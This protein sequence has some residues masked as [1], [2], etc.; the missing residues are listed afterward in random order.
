MLQIWRQPVAWCYSTGPS[1][2]NNPLQPFNA[3]PQ[4]RRES[5][6]RLGAIISF[7][8]AM[9]MV[10]DMLDR[11]I[12]DQ[13]E[14]VFIPLRP[15]EKYS[16]RREYKSGKSPAFTSGDIYS[17]LDPVMSTAKRIYD[18]WGCRSREGGNTKLH[19]V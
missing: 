11:G 12:R 14:E 17:G 19:G 18:R 3:I 2:Q 9:T 15:E 5:I 4:K 7:A 1:A 8:C 6:Q 13:L 16:C 10:V